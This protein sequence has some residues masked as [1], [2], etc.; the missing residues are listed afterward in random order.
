[1][2]LQLKSVVVHAQDLCTQNNGA[3]QAR[4]RHMYMPLSTTQAYDQIVCH[5]RA[6][7]E[8]LNLKGLILSV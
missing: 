4:G 6:I 3:D 2:N 8:E 5:V 7:A 1:M